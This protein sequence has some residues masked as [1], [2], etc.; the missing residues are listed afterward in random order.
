MMAQSKIQNLKSSG[1]HPVCSRAGGSGD[2][3]INLDFSM[4]IFDWGDEDEW[5]NLGGM[6]GFFFR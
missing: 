6:A 2:Q 4:P 3:V 5:N 1:F